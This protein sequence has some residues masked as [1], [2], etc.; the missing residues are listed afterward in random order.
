[1]SGGSRLWHNTAFGKNVLGTY[2]KRLWYDYVS[3][4]IFCLNTISIRDV[5]QTKF[6]KMLNILPYTL[7]LIYKNNSQN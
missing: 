4:L 7:N 6:P 3:V 5:F 2:W 1:M